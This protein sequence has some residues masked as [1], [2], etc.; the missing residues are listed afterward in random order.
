MPHISK[1]DLRWL[2]DHAVQGKEDNTPRCKT[3]GVE[4]RQVVVGRSIWTRPF[5]GGSGEV[6]Q[7]MHPYCPKCGKAPN[8]SHGDP[9][10]ED[11]LTEI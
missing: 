10:Y 6:R 9:I 3:T 7:V 11:E 8:V 5:L 1:D 2:L 4:I